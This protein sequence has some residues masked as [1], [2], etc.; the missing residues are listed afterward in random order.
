MKTESN[1]VP[2]GVM[3]I[4]HK[5][6]EAACSTRVEVDDGQWWNVPASPDA[7]LA[8]ADALAAEWLSGLNAMRMAP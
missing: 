3:E 5:R 6:A 4:L 8:R 2:Q 7:V 1:E